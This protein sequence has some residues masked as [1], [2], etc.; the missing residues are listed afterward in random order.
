MEI[1]DILY[2]CKF[3]QTMQPAKFLPAPGPEPRPLVVCLHTW[4]ATQTQSSHLRYAALAEARKWHFIFPNFRG[5][6]WLPDGC[7]SDLVVSDLEDAVA[8]VKSVAAVDP[9][10][11]YLT[12]GSGGGHCSLL[13]AGRRPDLWT[14]VS[15]WCPISD[16]ARWHQECRKSGRNYADHIES[17]CGGDPAKS[18]EVLKEAR[19][20]S[21]LTWLP[22]AAGYLPVDIGTGIHDGH[23]GS[24]PIGQAIRAYNLLA[25]PEDRISDE[26]IAYMEANE[27]VP[28]HLAAK[29][30]D[31][32]YG[33]HIV[34]LRKQSRKVR[35]TLFEGGHN[36]LPDAG[37]DWLER[38]VS[39][40]TPDWGP[41][42]PIV[43]EGDTRLGK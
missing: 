24:V 33:D 30:G 27:K 14:A 34:Y 20:R 38:Q 1:Q 22:N 42:K 19:K 32:S 23:K 11:V 41:G 40:Q 4:S 29:E 10:R 28:E 6:N 26:D 36:M 43:T 39:G 21:P 13:M 37:F 17:A 25:A 16:V 9:A 15:A 35:L 18:E 2:P 3:D 12:G 7:G 8:Y 31:P 5:P